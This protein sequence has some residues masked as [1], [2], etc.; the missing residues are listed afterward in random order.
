MAAILVAVLLVNIRYLL[1]S[2]YMA[3]FLMAHL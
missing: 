3:R 1:M 2:S